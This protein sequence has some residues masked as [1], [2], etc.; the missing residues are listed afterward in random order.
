MNHE[1]VANHA[2]GA[3]S[4][5]IAR[6]GELHQ[7]HESICVALDLGAVGESYA[8]RLLKIVDDAIEAN[9]ADIRIQSAAL[10]HYDAARYRRH[11]CRTVS[12]IHRL[13]TKPETAE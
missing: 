1:T 10:K 2:A 7:Q 3:L 13:H 12:H 6:A 11:V 5:A 4:A 9:A 8:A